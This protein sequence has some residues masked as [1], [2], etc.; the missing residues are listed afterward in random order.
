MTNGIDS[1][2]EAF[3]R[4]CAKERLVI[5]FGE[6]DD[7]SP[8]LAVQANAGF[9]HAA[10]HLRAISHNEGTPTKWK[11]SEALEH[12]LGN[13]R[14]ERARIYPRFHGFPAPAQEVAQLDGDGE[15]AHAV[16]V[17]S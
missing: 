7:G 6:D 4:V 8:R 11:H 9:S 15:R 3:E 10:F 14:V 13:P 1:Q 12:G 2:G 17:A 16:S 5:L